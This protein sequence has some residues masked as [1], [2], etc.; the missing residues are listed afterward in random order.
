MADQTYQV[1]NGT[2]YHRD[3]P[4]TVIDVLERARK[5]GSRIRLHYGDTETGRDWLDEFNVEGRIG[6]SMGPIK[7]PILLARRTSSGG[8][9]LLEHCI[10]KIRP[11][12]SG[13]RILYRHP[14]YHMPTFTVRPSTEPGFEAEVLADGHVHARFKSAKQATRWVAR[15]TG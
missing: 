12:R 5:T 8:P 10:V 14:R 1:T 4:A 3:A 6:R 11:A 15:M 2:Y 7:V 9:A 13:G